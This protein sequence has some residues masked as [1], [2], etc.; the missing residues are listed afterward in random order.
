[1]HRDVRNPLQKTGPEL[2]K[3]GA[4]E[5]AR[6]ARMVGGAPAPYISAQTPLIQVLLGA[7]ESSYPDLQEPSWVPQ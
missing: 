5:G 4:R 7:A 3:F 1:M 6:R 2:S